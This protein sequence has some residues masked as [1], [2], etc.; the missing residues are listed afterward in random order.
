[1]AGVVV[2]YPKSEEERAKRL[3]PHLANRFGSDLILRNLD[4]AGGEKWEAKIADAMTGAEV[5]LALIGPR[6][7]TDLD[8]RRPVDDPESVCRRG[9]AGKNPAACL[10]RHD[11]GSRKKGPAGGRGIFG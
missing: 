11:G 3:Y 1:M 9:E 4:E 8:G 10:C 6:W 2:G 5:V 7:L